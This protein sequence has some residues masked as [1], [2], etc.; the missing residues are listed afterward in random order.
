MKAFEALT[1]RGQIGRLRKLAQ[2]ALRQY[3]L[4][5]VRLTFIARSENTV[6]RVDARGK[7][8]ALRVHRPGHQTET[9]LVSELAWMAALRRDTGL[10]LPEPQPSLDG[11][12]HVK[13]SAPGV[14]GPRNVSL[15]S[16]VEGRRVV[17]SVRPAH[18]AALGKLMAR[19]HEHAAHWQPPPGFERRHWDWDGLFGDQAGLDRPASEAWAQMPDRHRA[20]FE[21]VAQ[22]TRQVMAEW[23]KTPDVYGLIHS[24]LFLGKEGNLLFHR[25][26]PIPIDFDDCGYGYWLYDLSTPLTHW[27]THPQYD[28]YRR[29]LLDGYA[30]VRSLTDEQ[31]DRLELFMAARHVSEMVWAVDQATSNTAFRQELDGW[32]QWAALHVAR[33]QK[34]KEAL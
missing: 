17:G 16:W 1:P 26:Q 9:S 28:V 25:G 32:L 15:L 30:R 22:E 6:F 27:Q 23:G 4:N 21:A 31:L 29:A 19:L 5:D 2:T 20:S 13:V 34:T 7:R 3:G 18:F 24:D 8:L 14:P 10:P 33:Y 12:L 11:A